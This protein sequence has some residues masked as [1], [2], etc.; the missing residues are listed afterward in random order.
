MNYKTCKILNDKFKLDAKFNILLNTTKKVE[1]TG[2]LEKGYIYSAMFFYDEVSKELGKLEKVIRRELDM[3][4]LE[5]PNMDV[6][7]ML[8]DLSRRVKSAIGDDSLDGLVKEVLAERHRHIALAPEPKEIEKLDHIKE[9]ILEETI[10]NL[11]KT[12]IEKPEKE[13][14][15]SKRVALTQN[16][17][18]KLTERQKK[19]MS[20]AIKMVGFLN[21][22]K[23]DSLEVSK[24]FVATFKV[25]A[26]ATP[27]AEK[28]ETLKKNLKKLI[29]DNA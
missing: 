15:G 28:E 17:V 18:D 12:I 13:K 16:F 19:L 26:V 25:F 7:I 24:D 27:F 14:D 11:Y 29:E 3:I 8:L 21:D 5:N 2:G 10:D 9:S 22:I 1:V 20:P 4:T 23:V 6:S